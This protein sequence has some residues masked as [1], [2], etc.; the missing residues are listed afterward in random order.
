MKQRRSALVIGI[1]ACILA[2][3]GALPLAAAPP[4]QAIAPGGLTYRLADTWTDQP[5]QPE[6]GRFGRVR[7]ISSAPDGTIF[8]LDVTHGFVH[9]LA[10]DGTPLRYFGVPDTNQGRGADPW[11]ACNMDVG[12]D[13]LVYVLSKQIDHPDLCGYGAA[14]VDRLAPDGRLLARLDVDPAQRF[15]YADLAV[16]PDG[17]L[18]LSRFGADGEPL[19]LDGPRAVDVFSPDGELQ[20]SLSPPE[21]GM[22]GAIDVGEDGRAYVVN[23]VPDAGAS[24]PGIPDPTPRPSLLGAD[25]RD[26]ALAREEDQDRAPAQA[27]GPDQ[28]ATPIE[29][30]LILD[31]DHRY[32]ETVPFVNARDVAVGPA[33]VFVSRD[34]DIYPLRE[35]EPVFA[36]PAGYYGTGMRLDVPVDGRVL[37]GMNHC[38]FQGLVEIADPRGRPAAGR[39]L[40]RLDKPDLEGPV[41]PLRMAASE[42]IAVL[43]GAF[44]VWGERPHLEYSTA[45]EAEQPQTVQRWTRRGVPAGGSAIAPP[46]GRPDP[47][48][49][50]SPPAAGDGGRGRLAAQLGLCGGWSARPT[51]D[52]AIDGRDVY[53]VDAFAV[54]RRPDDLP[55][56]WT[57]VPEIVVEPDSSAFLSAIA[58]DQGRVAVLDSGGNRV[59]MADRSGAVVATWDIAGPATGSLPVDLAISAAAGRV[60]LADQGASRILVRGLDGS[61]LGEWPTHDGPL[62]VALG[63]SG[64]V[65]VLGRGGWGF[66]YRAD[67]RLVA[68]WPMPDRTLD[69]LDIAVDVDERVYINFVDRGLGA[70]NLWSGSG[71]FDIFHAGLWVF[72]PEALPASPA[73]A[74]GACVAVP[75]KRAAPRRIPLGATVEITLSVEGTCP[76][77]YDPVQLALVVDT[78]RSMGMDDALTR[79]RRAVL[80][81][82]G[83][84]DPRAAEVALVSFSDGGTL[85][86]PLSSNLTDIGAR[87]AGLAADGD[88]RM[89]AGLDIARA[90][91]TGP[92][93]DPARRRVIVLVSDGAFKD[94]P[95]SAAARVRAAGIELYALVFRNIEFDG[96]GIDPMLELEAMTGATERVLLEPTPGD[97]TRLGRDMVRY[98]PEEGLFETIKITDE[99]P[100][101]MRYVDDSAIPP[102]HF[103]PARRTLTWTL[104]D[105]LATDGLRLR[106][107]VL[108]LQVGVWPTNVHAE[109]DYHDVL[110]APGRLVFPI[111][112]V[113]VTGPAH[114]IYLPITADHSC[115]R[116]PRPLDVVLVIDTSS[117]MSDPAPGGGSKLD[118][119]RA[120]AGTFVDLLDLASD[121]VA[122]VAFDAA[123]R[124]AAGLTGDRAALGQALSLLATFRGT[125]ID[126][127]LAEAAAV[128][129]EGGRP[130]ATPAVIL[131]SDGLQSAAEAPNAAVLAQAD[132]LKAAGTLVHA[133]GLGDE[134]DRELLRA[135]ASAPDRYHE[136]P[137]AAD[138]AAIYGA[139]SVRLGCGGGMGP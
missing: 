117:S 66:R 90:E 125:R 132:R 110:G 106:Y 133:I 22:P 20:V 27:E 94:R 130:D 65:F 15:L 75:D 78:S 85:E 1:A 98:Q 67:G 97:L 28:A 40:G 139:I 138:L 59:I 5:W 3:S 101:N 64:D 108:P 9:V 111:P 122:L 38:Y 120:A 45:L 62:R 50:P 33:G 35:R 114:Q 82:L 31:P 135:V 8:V 81:L 14:R 118:A 102:A 68:A 48:G 41:F 76:G 16:H 69:A 121:R 43:Q 57:L 126:L 6:A 10:P 39:Y 93:G 95:Q 58:A 80:A 84:L 74:A 91:L 96:L 92:R 54:Q 113:E 53:T 105:I 124:R 11:L 46:P 18:Y 55:P 34:S 123:A 21:L 12:F 63:P 25:G 30:V 72:E 44:D 70:P 131:L 136:S 77:V 83:A 128:L 51:H 99:V 32:R 89:G 115:L 42:E 109:A 60:Y 17:R 88:S 13:G 119:A 137:T 103:D 104:A 36:G 61:D 86:L 2:G 127:G 112:E 100:A 19:T 129:A 47:P 26:R 24:V 23:R 79:A 7:D 107:H 116:R 29:G 4:D 73:P 52:V 37:A 71:G 49:S 134:V 87:V 56:A